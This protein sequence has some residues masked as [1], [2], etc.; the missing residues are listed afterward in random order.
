MRRRTQR[1]VVV[2]VLI[3]KYHVHDK[4]IQFNLWVVVLRLRTICNVHVRNINATNST[5]KMM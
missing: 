2:Y 3:F 1:I 5:E 4:R